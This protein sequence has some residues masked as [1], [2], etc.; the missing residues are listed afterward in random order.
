MNTKDYYMFNKGFTVLA[1]TILFS[2]V[3]AAASYIPTIAASHIPPAVDI[4]TSTTHH[5][6]F[7]DKK[8]VSAVF[9]VKPKG[10]TLLSAVVQSESVDDPDQVKEYRLDNM[11]FSIA[12]D[13]YV[14]KN[15]TPQKVSQITVNYNDGITNDNVALLRFDTV[16]E[17]F[18]SVVFELPGLALS[19]IRHNDQMKL[20]LPQVIFPPKDK[21]CDRVPRYCYLPPNPKQKTIYNTHI[22]MLHN[23]LN[24]VAFPPFITRII[25][26]YCPFFKEC[27]KYGTQPLSYASRNMLSLG[28]EGHT[29]NIRVLAGNYFSAGRGG[30]DRPWTNNKKAANT[31]GKAAVYEGYITKGSGSYRPYHQR[32]YNT[33]F[34]ETNHAFGFSHDSAMTY[35]LGVP[36]SQ[37]FITEN[38]SEI[39][40]TTIGEVNVPSVFVTTELNAKNEMTLAFYYL[41]DEKEYEQVSLTML[42][43]SLNSGSV[44]YKLDR[45]NKPVDNTLVLHFDTLPTA[46]TYIR[47]HNTDTK[48][49]S[50]IKL[51]PSELVPVVTY[52]IEGNDYGILDDKELLNKDYNGRQIRNLCTNMDG[53][54]A[55]KDEYQRLWNDLKESDKLNLLQERIFLSRDEPSNN[56]IWK[57]EFNDDAMLASQ[58]S[59]NDKLGTNKSLVCVK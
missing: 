38:F 41:P 35:G 32:T 5:F 49:L 25:N 45:N 16:V 29:F 7:S 21:S 11:T 39:D 54:L 18:S 55:T 22:V 36:Y 3:A 6:N 13:E 17:P 14:F 40:R 33:F 59:I 50:T 23:A 47:T 1:L 42:G 37:V 56:T 31:S 4:V 44:A 24:T 20:F 48:Y 15:T 8:E 9:S 2:T 30:G 26:T 19:N 34:H 10:L 28:A 58:H 52:N 12:D 53:L 43:L 27:K 57:L 46:T 51:S